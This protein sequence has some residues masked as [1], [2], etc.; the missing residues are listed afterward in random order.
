MLTRMTKTMSFGYDGDGGLG[1]R[2]I[3]SVL[4]GE[5]TAT[6]SLAIG[7]LSGELPARRGRTVAACRS[8][9]R[10]PRSRRNHPGDYHPAASDRDTQGPGCSCR[11]PAVTWPRLDSTTSWRPESRTGGARAH[12]ASMTRRR[13]SRSSPPRRTRGTTSERNTA[14]ADRLEGEGRMT[15]AGRRALGR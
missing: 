2:L 7:Y 5:K 15:P 1:D 4:R 14:I 11:H 10:R 3:A 9:G 8:S 13:T 12:V 6:S